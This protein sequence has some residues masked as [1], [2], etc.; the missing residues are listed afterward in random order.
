MALTRRNTIVGLG[1]LAAGAGVIGGTGAFT[2][3]EADRTVTVEAAGD[4][5]ALLVFR[6]TEDGDV[7]GD[8]EAPDVFSDAGDELLELEVS[9][10]N[11]QARTTFDAGLTVVN[12]GT[13]DVGLYVDE[14]ESENIGAGE[15]IADITHDGDSIIGEGE[16]VDLN[17]GEH[18]NIGFEFDLFDFASTGDL[19]DEIDTNEPVIRFVAETDAHSNN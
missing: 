14:G 1:A 18:V 7:D 19:D 16:A 6:P 15:V 11:L 5:R 13:N 10:L 3:V 12:T 17:A 8:D 2:A 4:D 9:D